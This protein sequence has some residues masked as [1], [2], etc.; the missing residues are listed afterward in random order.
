MI[1]VTLKQKMKGNYM[2]KNLLKEKDCFEKD[3]LEEKDR[4]EESDS[5]KLI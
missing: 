3:S 1:K 2:G 5:K 4:F